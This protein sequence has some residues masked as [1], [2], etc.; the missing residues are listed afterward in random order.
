[1]KFHIEIFGQNSVLLRY[2]CSCENLPGTSIGADNHTC[3]SVGGC[4][5]NNGGCSHD[6]IDSYNQVFCMCPVGF[7]LGTDWKTCEVS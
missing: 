4:A 6:C 1:M 2:K 3:Q 5:L 7:I